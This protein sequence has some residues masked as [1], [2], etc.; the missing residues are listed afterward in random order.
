[1]VPVT[2]ATMERYQQEFYEPLFGKGVELPVTVGTPPPLIYDLYLDGQLFQEKQKRAVTLALY[3][4]AGENFDDPDI[5]RQ[6]LRYLKVA[7]GIVFLIDPLQC[8]AVREMLP[9]TV[10]LPNADATAEPS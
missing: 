2:R 5:V 4:T 7:S 9:S 1:M 8:P 6:M 10:P 3:D